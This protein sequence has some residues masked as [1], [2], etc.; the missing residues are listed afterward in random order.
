MLRN[1][2][3]TVDDVQASFDV[4]YELN[5]ENSSVHKQDSLYRRLEDIPI[6]DYTLKDT[7]PPP[8]DDD[9]LPF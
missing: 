8:D 2:S 6:E 9:N 5:H 1:S 7:K 4:G 3:Y